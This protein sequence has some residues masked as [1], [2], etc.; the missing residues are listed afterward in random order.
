MS[1]L[2][3][4]FTL[5]YCIRNFRPKVKFIRS[6]SKKGRTKFKITLVF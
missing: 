6:V 3:R 5:A 1:E 4:L 2:K